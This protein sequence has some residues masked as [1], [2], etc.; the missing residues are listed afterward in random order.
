MPKR[1]SWLE[2]REEAAGEEWTV[3]KR[4]SIV[5]KTGLVDSHHEQQPAKA[6]EIFEPTS[7]PPT[8]H[9]SASFVDL[10]SIPLES[11]PENISHSVSVSG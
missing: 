5:R 8:V 7:P 6:P 9:E 10:D 3:N 11:I 4:G 1:R 2:D